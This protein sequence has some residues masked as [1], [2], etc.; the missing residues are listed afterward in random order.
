[1]NLEPLRQA[2]IASVAGEIAERER[3][4][5]EATAE[6]LAAAHARSDRLIA[7]GR[8]EGERAAVREVARIRATAVRTA[9]ES[10]LRAQRNLVDELRSHA[11]EEALS[12]RGDPSY[13]QLLDRLTDLAHSQLGADAEL[14]R[15][16]PGA[17]G[18]RART[19]MRSVDYTLPTL[20]DRTLDGLGDRLEDLWR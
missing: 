4:D 10:N 11:L 3:R 20:V 16:P 7:Q 17:G 5:G 13:G 2:L 6:Q 1:M 8:L 12:M 19:G 14:E 9:R 18:L 15:D